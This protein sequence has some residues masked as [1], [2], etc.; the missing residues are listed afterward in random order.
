MSFSKEKRQ[1]PWEGKN[2]A[3]STSIA[4]VQA[5]FLS[6]VFIMNLPKKE[7]LKEFAEGFRG[8]HLTF[9]AKFRIDE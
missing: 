5:F 8:G 9:D 2:L 1:V 4:A 3:L 7:S 6:K